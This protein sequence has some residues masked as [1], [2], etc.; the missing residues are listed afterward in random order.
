MLRFGAVL[1]I[2]ATFGSMNAAAGS[3]AVPATLAGLQVGQEKVGPS[4]GTSGAASPTTRRQYLTEIQLYSLRQ[5]NQQLEATIQ[6]GRF[7]SGS[8]V[9]ARSFQRQIAGQLGTTVPREQRVGGLTV[10]ITK[11]KKLS[12]VV[13]FRQGRLFILSIREGYPSPKTLIREAVRTEP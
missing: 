12:L 7:R 6:I 9:Q 8:P 2:V 4:T 11:G 5:P 13:W 1:L 10:Y 3:S